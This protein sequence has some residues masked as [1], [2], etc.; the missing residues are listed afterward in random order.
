MTPDEELERLR[1]RV[2]ELER[3]N[4]KLRHEKSQLDEKVKAI[5]REAFR[6]AVLFD[7]VIVFA[8]R[9][10]RGRGV[11][12]VPGARPPEP[13]HVDEEVD[14]PLSRCPHCGGRVTDVRP[15]KQTVEDIPAVGPV[16]TEIVTYKGTCADCGPVRSMHPREVSTASGEARVHV[17]PRAAALAP[18]LN[19]RLGIPPR[20]RARS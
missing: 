15:I 19:K 9:S 7:V 6:Q 3:E 14:A 4:E 20:R 8:P 18:D 12:P 17:S 10:P 13:K 1:S 16:V 11:E 5:S 2:P